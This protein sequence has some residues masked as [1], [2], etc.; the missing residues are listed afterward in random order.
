ME[1]SDP[2]R[3][4]TSRTIDGSDP[5]RES[6]SSKTRKR[7]E[8]SYKFHDYIRQHIDDSLGVTHLEKSRRHRKLVK[9]QLTF[10]PGLESTNNKISK[11][12]KTKESR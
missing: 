1:S 11:P 9:K 3:S 12:K 4:P 2:S 10:S 8:E 6:I 5:I 7:K